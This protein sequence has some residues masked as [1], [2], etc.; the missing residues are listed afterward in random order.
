[1][2]IEAILAILGILLAFV[3]VAMSAYHL[4]LLDGKEKHELKQLNDRVAVAEK[5]F[6]S[7]W[8]AYKSGNLPVIE[9]KEP[10]DWKN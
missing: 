4:G 3:G 10:Q 8:R 5:R 1:M 2:P 7:A 6:Q 9:R